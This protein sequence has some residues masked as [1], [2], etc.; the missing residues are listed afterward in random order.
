MSE[1]GERIASL[2]AEFKSFRNEVLKDNDYIKG[3]VDKILETLPLKV[4][5]PYCQERHEVLRGK[6]E[7]VSKNGR[8][9]DVLKRIRALEQKTPAIIQQVVLAI[10]TAV[11]T[12]VAVRAIP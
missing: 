9:E 11:L 6:L 7:E 3:K 10:M 2:E 4:D 1:I 8:W 12:A 5:R